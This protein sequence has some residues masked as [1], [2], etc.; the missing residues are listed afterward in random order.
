[1]EDAGL[2]LSMAILRGL[3]APAGLPEPVGRR[4][5][6]ALQGVAADPE[7]RAEADATGFQVAWVDSAAWS[8]AAR[9]E[10][11]DLSAL[12]PDAPHRTVEAASQPG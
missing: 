6:D 7:F 4:L 12:W 10:R 5:L 11:D 9:A 3:V 8:A 1:M 2:K